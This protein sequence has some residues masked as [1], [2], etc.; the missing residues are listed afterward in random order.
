MLIT[1]APEAAAVSR[2]AIS[3]NTVAPRS[4]SSG[5]LTGPAVPAP[6]NELSGTASIRLATS[7]PWNGQG[8]PPEHRMEFGTEGE[9]KPP[10]ARSGS[11]ELK[12]LS[13]TARR[14][15]APSRPARASMFQAAGT[16]IAFRCDQVN[17]SWPGASVVE[18][19]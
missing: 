16:V 14:G 19:V 11:P 17:A 18:R 12:P 4:N 9:A 1:R 8:V 13:S 5:V 3:E 15:L 7:E 10:G 2:A 6:P